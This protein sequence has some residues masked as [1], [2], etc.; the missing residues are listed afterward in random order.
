MHY[1]NKDY[2]KCIRLDIQPTNNKQ[3]KKCHNNLNPIKDTIN[4][5]K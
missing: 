4:G 5:D 3:T 1:S 2:N